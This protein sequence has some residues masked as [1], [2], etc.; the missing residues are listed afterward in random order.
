MAP[1][2]STKWATFTFW[3]V[4]NPVL[5]RHHF[6]YRRKVAV[7]KYFESQGFLVTTGIG[8][9]FGGAVYFVLVPMLPGNGAPFGETL[10]M[11]ANGVLKDLGLETSKEFPIFTLLR[12]K[13]EI[14][15]R[16]HIAMDRVDVRK[17]KDEVARL[18]REVDALKLQQQL[19]SSS[20]TPL[21][22]A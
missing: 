2:G 18:K 9:L 16:I 1:L 8:V 19:Q 20:P 14:M 15:N 4:I 21:K 3:N 13:A 17:Q 10:E 5:Q 7:D 22:V 11:N 12:A 6:Y